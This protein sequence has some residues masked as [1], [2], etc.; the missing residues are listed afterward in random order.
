MKNE[1]DTVACRLTAPATASLDDRK[2]CW[3]KG[4][5]SNFHFPSKCRVLDITDTTVHLCKCFI[6]FSSWQPKK[7][8]KRPY[9]Y[10]C[11][12]SIRTKRQ[13]PNVSTDDVNRSLAEIAVPQAQLKLVAYRRPPPAITPLP[14]SPDE[15]TMFATSGNARMRRQHDWC[16]GPPST[17][18]RCRWRQQ[19]PQANAN[20]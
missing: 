19:P 2:S 17:P 18:L 20:H 15:P 1:R 9:K 5:L 11:R 13:P 8:K 4:L 3:R 10:G 12:C 7:P 16:S 14:Q 6:W